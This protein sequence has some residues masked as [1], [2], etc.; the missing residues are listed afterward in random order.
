MDKIYN[1]LEEN[2]TKGIN[3]ALC[4]VVSTSGSTPLNAGA[5]MLV[6]ESGQIHG[7]IGGGNLEKKVIDN[8]KEVLKMKEPKLFQHNLFQ[9][10]GMC[11]GGTVHIYI[12]PV[13]PSNKLYIF[14]SGH[15]GRALSNYASTLSFDVYVIDD[16]M[17]ELNKINNATVNKLP[18]SYDEILPSLP[19]SENI[20]IAIMTHDHQIDRE[21]LAYCLNKSFA[22]LGMIGSKRKVE[23]TKKMLLSTQLFNAD[24]LSKID[25]PMGYNTNAN[26]PEEIA[27]SI[28]VKIIEVKNT[29]PHYEQDIEN[30]IKLKI[31]ES[32]INNG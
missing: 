3:L 4:V 13:L 24:D 23:V 19:F 29:K 28:L 15:V 5:K 10:H 9:Q 7:T 12:E 16:R 17:D 20:F 31:N 22:Y 25:M 30:R 18:F 14:G 32:I 2:R 8:A 1:I 26:N 27:I 6:M 21:I 11:C